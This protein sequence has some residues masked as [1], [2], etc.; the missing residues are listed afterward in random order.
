MEDRLIKKLMT[1]MKCESCGHNYEVYNVDVLGHREDLW[2]LRVHCSTCR[3][4]CLVAAVVKEGRA[5]ETV[6]DPT[7]TEQG[8]FEKDMIEVDDVLNMHNFLEYFEG[9]FSRLFGQE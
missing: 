1:S 4:Q 3:T 8:D 9:D 2:F 7:E 6:A 5:H